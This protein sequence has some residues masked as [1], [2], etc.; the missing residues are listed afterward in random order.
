MANHLYR[1]SVLGVKGG[2]GKSTIALS[3]SL[4]LAKS[5]KNVLLIDRDILGYA[6]SVSGIRG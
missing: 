1:I 4:L 6:S 3:L 5:S 2:V